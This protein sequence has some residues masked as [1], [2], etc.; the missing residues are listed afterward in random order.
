MLRSEG[1]MLSHRTSFSS[2][3]DSTHGHRDGIPSTVNEESAR[4]KNYDRSSEHASDYDS[5]LDDDQYS[6]ARGTD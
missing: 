5:S 3:T 4:V 2:S 6:S 1:E